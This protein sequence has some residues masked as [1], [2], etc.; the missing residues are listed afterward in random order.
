MSHL[1]S[2]GLSVALCKDK[3]TKLCFKGSLPLSGTQ[4]G[5]GE[6][7]RSGKNVLAV[8]SKQNNII[9]VVFQPYK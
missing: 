2:F 7:E 9:Q 4:V 3:H 5:G 8:K 1:S 6:G